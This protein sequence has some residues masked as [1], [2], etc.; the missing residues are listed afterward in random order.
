MRG[1][2]IVNQIKFE[3]MFE[4]S[5]RRKIEHFLESGKPIATLTKG[6]LIT[7][8]LGGIIAV[9]IMAPNLFQALGMNRTERNKR[10]S[11][12]GFYRVRRGMYHLQRKRFITVNPLTGGWVLTSLGKKAVADILNSKK[13][14][15]D[16]IIPLPRVWDKK[17]RLI[18]FDIPT[19][20]NVARD[21]LRRELVAMGC[22]SLQKSVLAH[23]FSC[24]K[25]IK[26]L[27]KL[28]NIE[29]YIYVYTAEEPPPAHVTAAFRILLSKV[30]HVL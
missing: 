7:A 17:T 18:F 3:K 23:P 1:K 21:T 8:A 24:A 25:E 9:G 28:L 26:K 4:L 12:E 20:R 19:D 27:A 14:K 2:R 16:I 10:F 30:S 6:L 13:K 11:K 5:F 15:F 29:K 22:V